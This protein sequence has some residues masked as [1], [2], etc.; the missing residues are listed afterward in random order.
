MST[1]SNMPTTS[2]TNNQDM[3]ITDVA[4]S[5]PA[6][7]WQ[8]QEPVVYRYSTSMARTR[9]RHYTGLLT[10]DSV[11][12]MFWDDDNHLYAISQS[13]GSCLSL[14]LLRRGMVKLQD[15]RTQ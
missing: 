7:F 11:N 9:S 3:W 10:T 13:A 1:D 15:R 4:M 5:P 12:Q 8:L 14:P 6:S 2:V